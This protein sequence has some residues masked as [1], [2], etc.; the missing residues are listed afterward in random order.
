MKLFTTKIKAIDPR[1]GKLKIWLGPNV[2]GLSFEDAEMHCQQNRLGYCKVIGEIVKEVC[3]ID[4][5]M[6]N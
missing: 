5:V 4:N 6:L 1:D 2:P 3:C